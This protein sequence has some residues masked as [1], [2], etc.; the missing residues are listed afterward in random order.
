[1]T[2]PLDPRTIFFLDYFL[3]R[4]LDHFFDFFFYP[5]CFWTTL[6]GGGGWRHAISTQEVMGCSQSVLKE[7]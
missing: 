3:D 2:G 5:I 7:G 1:M 6:A 4:F